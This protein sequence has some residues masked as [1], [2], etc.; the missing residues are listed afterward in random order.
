M[1]PTL[2][3]AG[4]S[5][6]FGRIVFKY[7]GPLFDLT[8]KGINRGYGREPPGIYSGIQCQYYSANWK[9]NLD[10]NPTDSCRK[11]LS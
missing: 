10:L 3:I 7:E 8:K 2:V 6:F 5:G 11:E 1:K 9:I 4:A